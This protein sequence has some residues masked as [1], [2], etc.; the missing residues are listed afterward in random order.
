M[1]CFVLTVMFKTPLKRK[2]TS[3]GVEQQHVN[4]I[5]NFLGKGKKMVGTTEISVMNSILPYQDKRET[6]R[7]VIYAEESNSNYYY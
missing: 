7:R 4:T 2:N 1:L 3:L 6:L 5:S